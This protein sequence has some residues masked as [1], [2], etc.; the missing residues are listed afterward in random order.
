M[1]DEN[2]D[3]KI[4]KLMRDFQL[5]KI[6]IVNDASTHNDDRKCEENKFYVED[7]LGLT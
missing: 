7:L 3:G 2:G 4:R 1:L 5:M 6:L